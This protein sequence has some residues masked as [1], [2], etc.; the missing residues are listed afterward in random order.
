MPSVKLK[1]H[2]PYE[3]RND[4]CGNTPGSGL[5]PPEEDEPQQ[6]GKNTPEQNLENRLPP[7]NHVHK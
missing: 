4:N 5:D 1:A 6:R 7:K 2:G 3:R